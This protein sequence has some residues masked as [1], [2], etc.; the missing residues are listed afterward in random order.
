[1]VCTGGYVQSGDAITIG[2]QLP[3]YDCYILDPDTME[4]QRQR[5]LSRERLP[6][7]WPLPLLCLLQRCD[8]VLLQARPGLFVKPGEG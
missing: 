2:A 1:M 5:A 8:F 4:A 6:L 7:L 3:T